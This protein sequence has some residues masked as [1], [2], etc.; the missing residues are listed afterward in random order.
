[1]G[2]AIPKIYRLIFLPE[3]DVFSTNFLEKASLDLLRLKFPSV[4]SYLVTRLITEFSVPFLFK[5]TLVVNAFGEI[6]ALSKQFGSVFQSNSAS[7]DRNRMLFI[8]VFSRVF[9]LIN[10]QTGEYAFSS[11]VPIVSTTWFCCLIV[12]WG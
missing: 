10:S 1:M 11:T 7:N 6:E 8:V 4:N 9:S 3:L 12:A 5:I 2:A